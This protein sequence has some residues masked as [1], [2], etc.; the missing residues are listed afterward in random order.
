MKDFI[1]ILKQSKK[2]CPHF[3]LSLQSGCDK[4][5]KK[6]NR[7]YTADE[8][9]KLCIKLRETF[10]DATITTDVMVG[11]PEESDEDFEESVKFCE[12]IGFEKVHVFP[13]SVRHG[14][15]AEKMEQI[16]KSVKEKRAKILSE[17]MEKNQTGFFQ[18]T[19]WKD[20]RSPC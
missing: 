13:F 11:F 19:G 3:H 5:L 16:E 7:H 10:S 2:F 8:Y 4:T 14:T 20:F 6:M 15:R 9:E 12:K 18:G 17:R 1:Q